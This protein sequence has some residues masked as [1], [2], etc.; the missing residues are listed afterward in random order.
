VIR[1]EL[2]VAIARPPEDVFALLTDVERVPDWQDSALESRCDGALRQGARIAERRR[3]MGHEIHTVL[4]VTE[5][6]PPRRLTLRT[7]EG[8]VPFTVEHEL[9]AD[10]DGTSVRVRAEGKPSGKLRFAAPVV[11]HQAEHELRADF[12]RL[13]DLLEADGA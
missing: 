4:E 3:I 7:L 10:G 11:K 1:I 5:Y 8:P 12:E 6:E 9:S 2:T 13:K